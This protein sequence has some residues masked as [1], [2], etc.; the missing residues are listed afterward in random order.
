[1]NADIPRNIKPFA[2]ERYMAGH[3][4][5][6][7]HLLCCSDCESLSISE[8]LALEEG[9]KER[10]LSM[11]LGYTES[12]GSPALRKEICGLYEN[13]S[14][15]ET[16]VHAG[17]QEAVHNFMHAVLKPGDE[18]IVQYP[19]YQSLYEVAASMGC[20][21]R[22][23]HIRHDTRWFVDIDEL[24]ELVR[25][26][27]KAV[28]VNSPHNPTGY[29]FS[30][31]EKLAIA[32]T[33]EILGALIFSDEVYR[34]TEYEKPQAALCDLTEKAVSLGVMSK[35]MGLPGLRI[36]WIASH[37]KEI[38]TRM[39]EYKDYTTICSSA[40]SEF[41]AGIALRNRET[42]LKRNNDLIKNN[43]RLLKGAL[44]ARAEIFSWLPPEGGPVAFV[45][46]KGWNAEAF[47]SELLE[48][49]GVLL[50][51]G[52]VFG[53]EYS[54]FIRF[55]MGRKSMP[56]ALKLLKKYCDKKIN[57]NKDNI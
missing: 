28:I 39:R 5:S 17:A 29:V 43:L 55:G 16:L 31:E 1:V 12:L 3:E 52:I 4:F 13:I 20:K 19:C 32:K 33:A 18:V 23:W 30:K 34:F 26:S 10:F 47:C 38:M 35:S 27:T 11:P 22:P 36:G 15:E 50:M 21:I 44:L 41:L 37:N 7:G 54:S 6:A 56:M 25:P 46:I 2:L 57:Q 53:E 42:I 40:P 24:S 14:P 49:T 45:G 51:P 9:A 48:D 8:V